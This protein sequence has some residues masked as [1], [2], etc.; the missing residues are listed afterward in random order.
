MQSVDGSEQNVNNDVQCSEN[1]LNSVSNDYCTF[2]TE[3]HHLKTPNSFDDF[4]NFQ[5]LI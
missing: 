3:N 2:L 4:Q 5:F 1:C